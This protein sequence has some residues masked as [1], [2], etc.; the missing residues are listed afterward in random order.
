MGPT[1]GSETFAELASVYAAVPFADK[2]RKRRWAEDYLGTFKGD[3]MFRKLRV[4]YH[5]C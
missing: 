3:G 4:S 2:A 1:V 5:I